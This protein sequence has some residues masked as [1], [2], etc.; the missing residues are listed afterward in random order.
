MV[1]LG[2]IQQVDLRA[3]WPR[4]AAEFT[5]WLAENLLALGTA[6]GVELELKQMEAPVG[7]FSLDIL[8]TEVNTNR[9]VAIENQLETT[10]HDHLGK[11]L[12]YASGFNAD[13]VIWIAKEIREEHR[14]ALDWLNQRT[15]TSTEF[16]G[17]V[18]ETFRIDDSRPAF[19]FDVVARPNQWRKARVGA[20]GGKATSE[21]GEAY[22]AF[23]Q[24]LID[25]LREEHKFTQARVGQPQSWYSFASGIRGV[26]FGAG[27]AQK[28]RVRAE[29]YID[30]GG[31]EENKRLFDDV[32]A[33][34]AEIEEAFG[35]ALAWERLD[36]ARASR[37]ALYRTG[38][39][40]DG[41]EALRDHQMWHVAN[42]LKL[43]QV[44]LPRLEELA[45]GTV[46]ADVADPDLEA[47][48]ETGVDV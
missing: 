35:E 1:E 18:V 31:Q 38:S 17:V 42:L 11:L 32:H 41:A 2:N 15:D 22:R 20:G 5:P 13:I 30:T 40:D 37:I 45:R 6:L 8:A 24:A 19:R 34:R 48:V 39:I 33:Q 3:V 43:K 7:T 21:R 26:S 36:N 27:Y 47:K 16:Y 12:T 9:N 29:V 28:N 23:F 44:I 4:E 10:N 46:P 14:Q 25:R